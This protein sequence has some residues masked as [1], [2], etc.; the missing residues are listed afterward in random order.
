M[1]FMDET[2]AQQEFNRAFQLLQQSEH[3]KSVAILIRLAKSFPSNPHV[4]YLLGVAHSLLGQQQLAV[5][6][7]TEAI[8]IQPDLIDA[9][10][11]K[12]ADLY[13]L[14][15]YQAAIHCAQVGLRI[16]P[17]NAMLL[18]N[19]GNSNKAIG[20]LAGALACYEQALSEAPDYAQA[21][22]NRSEVLLK[23][24]RSDEAISSAN[25]AIELLPSYADA[26]NNLALTHVELKQHSEALAAFKKSIRLQPNNPDVYN[27]LGLLYVQLAQLE[28]AVTAYEKSLALKPANP[29]VLLNLGNLFVNMKRF[30]EAISAYSRSVN[31]NPTKNWVKGSLLH[32]QMKVCDWSNY[33]K[34]VDDILSGIDKK[35]HPA[36]PFTLLGIPTSLG[37]QKLTANAYINFELP[38]PSLDPIP[39]KKGESK[40]RI[41]YLSA[42]F[43]KHPVAHLIAELLELHDRSRFEVI[44]ISY[45]LANEDDM[46]RRISRSVDRFIDVADKSDE[47]IARYIREAEVDIAIDLGGHTQGSR[48]GIL[49]FKPSPVQVHYLG[50]SGTTGAD[51]IDYLVADPV[52]VPDEHKL[53]YTEKIVHLPNAFQVNDR[54]RKIAVSEDSRADHGLPESGFVFC[55]F[56]NNWKITPD[57]FDV[58]MEILSKVEGSVLWLFKD[59]ELAEQN[60]RKESASRGINPERLVFAG[61]LPLDQHLARHRHADLFI[62]SFYFNAHTTASDAL[63]AGLPVLT[64]AGDTFASLAAAS[65]L[66][67]VGLPELVTYSVDEYENLAVELATNPERLAG[68]KQKLA[69]NR[70]TTPLFDTPRF[71]RHLENAYEQMIERYRQGLKPDHIHVSN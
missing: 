2:Q 12:S 16:Q 35:Q 46:R 1:A 10:V 4:H 43:H 64:K 48:L 57:L 50:Y 59:N 13:S 6:S 38:K 20:N 22:S 9:Y 29:D 47:G 60:L 33:Q 36:A 39:P 61:R 14:G 54:S 19:L 51:F 49:A 71:T 42:D 66:N 32:T 65:L 58:W 11:N 28:P 21:W 8:N 31:A 25:K 34:S 41:A 69:N 27:N 30:P 45:G 52:V 5:Q 37:I 44:G 70:L 24:G 63:W 67:A 55:C 62:D 7:Y 18:L 17:G 53:F 56:N 3:Q 15:A 40:L 68:L 23:L 26:Y